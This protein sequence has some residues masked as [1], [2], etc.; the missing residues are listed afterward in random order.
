MEFLSVVNYDA[1]KG[2]VELRKLPKPLLIDEDAVIMEVRN[3][4]VCGSDLHQWTSSHSWPVNYPVILGHEFS[5]V[6]H[7]VGSNVKNWQKGDRVVSETAA[8]IDV[9]NPLS[10]VGLYNLDPTRKGFGYGVNGA[11]TKYVVVPARCL[12]RIPDELSFETACLTEPCS[13]AYNAV[14]NNADINPGDRVIVIG[15]GTI[16]MLCALIAQLSG[17][18]VAVVG[19]ESDMPR[20]QTA[21]EYGLTTIMGDAGQW[22]KELDGMGVDCVIDTA[23]ISTTL[24][25]AMDWVRPDG[26]IIKVGWGPQPMGFSLD[27]IVQKNVRLQ[28]SFSHNWP[29]WEKVIR[30][31]ATGRLDVSKIIGGVWPLTEWEEAFLK[32]KNGEVIKSVLRPE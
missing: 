6:I 18:E 20:L 11:M 29:V 14:V 1:K 2:S 23:G 30:L 21:K 8:I 32:M 24:Q 31:L 4:G 25:N 3:V 22:A 15:P 10:K 5:G 26:Q 9:N 17:A 12:H 13:V 27:P 16:G 7:E 19:L 28:G